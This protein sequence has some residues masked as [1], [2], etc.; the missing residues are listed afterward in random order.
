[1]FW[2]VLGAE[3]ITK[4]KLA[5]TG[6]NVDSAFRMRYFDN[7]KARRVMGWAPE[8]GFEQTVRDTIEWMKADGQ[9]K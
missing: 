5:V 9:F 6:D 7:A 1:M 3:V 2:L 4:G 8:I